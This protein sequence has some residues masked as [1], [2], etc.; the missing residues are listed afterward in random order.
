MQTERQRDRETERQRERE[1]ERLE[2]LQTERDREF[3]IKKKLKCAKLKI[4]IFNFA[5]MIFLNLYIQVGSTL[6]NYFGKE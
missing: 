3:W 1:T 4:Y 6:W 2:N 5:Q